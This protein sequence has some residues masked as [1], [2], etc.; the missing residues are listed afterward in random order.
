MKEEKEQERGLLWF[1][2]LYIVRK[3]YLAETILLISQH[4][5]ESEVELEA[6]PAKNNS[7]NT[8][9]SELDNFMKA[10]CFNTILL[11]KRSR[12]GETV[13]TNGGVPLHCYKLL[14]CKGSIL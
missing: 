11:G 7:C 10:Y 13:I 1:A 14:Q 9:I 4:L 6:Q 2:C 5:I 3:Y 12:L 8:I